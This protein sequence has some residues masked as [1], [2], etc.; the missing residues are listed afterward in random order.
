MMI[1]MM[2]HEVE[3]V[4]EVCKAHAKEFW[5]NTVGMGKLLKDI[6]LKYDLQL[7]RFINSVLSFCKAD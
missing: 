3:K 1:A 7:S 5:R 2:L 4:G 6:F